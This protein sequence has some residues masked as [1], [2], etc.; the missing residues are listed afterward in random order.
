MPVPN[1]V[2]ASRGA[3]AGK[4]TRTLGFLVDW[5]K[6][7]YQNAIFTSVADAAA[8]YGANLICFTGGILDSPQLIWS[9][10]NV[11]YDLVGPHNLDA[12][13]ITAGTMG[14]LI[15]PERLAR[16]LERYRPLPIVSTAYDLPHCPSVIVDNDSGMRAV[17]SHLIEDHGHRRLAFV[18]GP[19]GQ[20]EAERR[21]RVYQEVLESHGIPFD[22]SLV[23]EGT[24][25][26][27]SGHQAA[28]WF[29]DR[30]VAFDAVVA[31]NDDMAIGV[32][33]ALQERGVAVPEQVAVVG[34]DDTEGARFSQPP[35]TTVRQP[36]QALGDEAVRLA[37]AIAEG[38]PVPKCVALPTELTIRQSCGCRPAAV[39]GA[40]PL[41]TGEQ[42]E[43][44]RRIEIGRMAIALSE[45]SKAFSG[46]LD[47]RSLMEALVQFL[48]DLRLPGCFIAVYDR[49]HAPLKGAQLR[50]AY[51]LQRPELT[52]A[53]A[54]AGEEVSFPTAS[55]AP[56]GLL[57]GGRRCTYVVEPLFF[58]E[59]Q[60]G[61]ATFEVGPREGFIYE[62]LRDQISGALKGAYL[63]QQVLDEAR[64]RQAAEKE[65]VDKE[66]KIAARIQTMILPRD[67]KV[68]GLQVAATML[69]AVNVGGDYYDIIP[70]EDGCWLA[71]GDVSGHGLS[72]G[73]IMLMIQ[74]VVTAVVE[75]DPTATPHKIVSTL[76]AVL[77]S[78]VRK[79][80]G[81]DE[82]ATFTAIRYFGDGRLLFA[83]AHESLIVYRAR[84]RR[85]EAFA[86]AGPWVGIV[87]NVARRTVEAECRLEDAD[88]LLLYTDG[89]VEAKN[90]RREYF[91]VD[92]LCAE[93]TKVGTQPV[94]QI[95]DHLIEQVKGWTS[96]QDDDMTVLVARHHR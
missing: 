67:A 51:D 95:R 94:E 12:L 85:C 27:P 52:L 73:L 76:N 92:R 18:R 6:D 47:V 31:A 33:E 83:G 28:R 32:M 81:L 62:A 77:Y 68:T 14:N 41:E 21:F 39:A 45:I 66:L 4:P 69:P 59:E 17:T 57:F 25:L 79:R 7:N 89:I 80:L 54:P 74:S 15:G 82:H 1:G 65:Q 36:I 58:D 71:V 34:F 60:I 3:A 43:G 88:V 49:A 26:R 84:E 42:L 38:Q 64:R 48:P 9:Q 78:N 24:F 86:T 55:L 75:T 2:A 96:V 53:G 10:R 20:Q 61:L 46:K 72:A 40:A 19:A 23:Y 56:E 11:L 30:G 29:L 93:L 35:L 87:E 90:L 37:L 63:V 70:V 91:G 50:L 22:R 8:R 13:V 44:R 16:Y 5:L